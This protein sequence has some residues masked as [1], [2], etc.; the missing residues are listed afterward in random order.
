VHSRGSRSG[1]WHAAR[2][3]S[4]HRFKSAFVRYEKRRHLLLAAKARLRQLGLG[5]QWTHAEE[6]AFSSWAAGTGVAR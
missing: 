1:L 5:G 4:V 6:E 3:L 2:E